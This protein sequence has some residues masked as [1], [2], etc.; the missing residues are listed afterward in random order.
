MADTPAWKVQARR[1]L[2]DA[3]RTA[4][5]RH[6]DP[7][8]RACE[9]TLAAV[10]LVIHRQTEAAFERGLMA[11]R[12]QSGYATRRKTKEPPCPTSPSV[13]SA[14]ESAASAGEP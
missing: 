6:G 2:R 11:G 10:A 9:D 4:H 1:D 14:D 3:V 12:S 13:P 5:D 7:P 8:C